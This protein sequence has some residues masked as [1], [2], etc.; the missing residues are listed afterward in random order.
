MR[1]AFLRVWAKSVP[2]LVAQLPAPLHLWPPAP[3]IR[4]FVTTCRVHRR[5]L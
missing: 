2:L 5:R 3:L 1:D 4:L